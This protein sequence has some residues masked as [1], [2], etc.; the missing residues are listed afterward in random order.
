MVGIRRVYDAFLDKFDEITILVPTELDSD[1]KSFSILLK[2]VSCPLV[3]D[4]KFLLDGFVKYVCKFDFDLPFGKTHLIVDDAGNQTDLQIGA[5]IRTVPFDQTF[6]YDGDD[7]GASYS[8]DKTLFKV[9]APTATGCKLKLYNPKSMIHE[10]FQM[11]RG[12]KGTW[13]YCAQDNLD[14]YYYTFLVRINLDWKEC[15]DPYAKAIAANGEYGVVINQEK[16]QVPKLS[17]PMLKSKTEAIIYECHI[18]DFSIDEESGMVNKAKYEAWLEEN[19]TNR[20]G[21]STGLLYLKEL[22]VTHVELLPINDFEEV[23][24]L[25]PLEAYNWGY[26]P[27]HFFAPEGSY[28]KDPQNPY[29]RILELKKLIQKLHECGLKV[30]IDVVYNHVY[31]K[32]NSS[33]EHLLPG[34]FFRHDENGFASNG[35]GVGNDLASERAMV[36]KFILDCASY[37]L[38]EYDVDGF[39]F[40]LMG[41]LDVETMSLLQKNIHQLKPDAFLLGEGWD[42]NTPIA[43]E[44]KAITENAH[45]LP[46][47]SFFNDQFRDVIKGST[48]NMNEHGY[49]YSSLEKVDQLTQLVSGSGHKFYHPDQSINYVES[50]DN[51]TMWDRF[52][53]VAPDESDEIRQA[54]HRFA[55]SLVI[56]SQGVPFL[57]A[58]QEFFRS[59]KGVENSYNSPDDI[60]K[61]HW[62]ARTVHKDNVEYVKGLIQLRKLHGAFRLPTKELINQHLI[63]QEGSI[64]HVVSY[65]LNE[66][67]HLGPW[68]SIL[69]VHYNQHNQEVDFYFPDEDVW[70]ELVNPQI[71]E[72]NDPKRRKNTLKLSDI[73]T[74][75]F[76]K[77]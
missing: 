60:N 70:H 50:H 30:I 54:R 58:G 23:D 22:G 45:T 8:K 49:V 25:K 55:T 27:R 57:H 43:R 16:T 40:D 29:V 61:I 32:E 6:S 15:V 28:S 1:T 62:Q 73:G 42:L 34:Y 37:W 7:L 74:Y 33:F 51:H 44:Q 64:D 39:R 35:T 12:N 10:T 20:N 75:V 56:L 17:V 3:V 18:R 26:N 38:E 69:V 21:D 36:R 48:F 76:C 5:I 68:N 14:G 67:G 77:N 59:K 66:V 53:L 41:I 46:K 11:T 19:T 13:Q 65:Q 52:H 63:L 31:S 72:L 9:W 71:V 24:D 47:I 4:D 2:E